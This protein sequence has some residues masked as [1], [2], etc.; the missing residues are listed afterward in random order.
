MIVMNTSLLSIC[1][2]I[3]TLAPSK[4]DIWVPIITVMFTHSTTSKILLPKSSRMVKTADE[5]EAEKAL[6]NPWKGDATILSRIVKPVEEPQKEA[7]KT[8]KK[9]PKGDAEISS[10]I[11]MPVEEPQEEAEKSLQKQNK[12][13]TP[14]SLT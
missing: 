7:E 12:I 1:S 14:R 6:K 10:R 5:E 13:H 11:A 4:G 3:I 8:L 9:P 2:C